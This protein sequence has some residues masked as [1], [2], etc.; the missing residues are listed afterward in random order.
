MTKTITP[1]Q[2][3]K[4][5]YYIDIDRGLCKYVGEKLYQNKL[6]YTFEYASNKKMFLEEN[7]LGLIRNYDNVGNDKAKKLN[8]LGDTSSWVKTKKKELEKVNKQSDELLQLYLERGKT[9]GYKYAKDT[10]EQIEF[11]KL[12]PYECTID[13]LNAVQDI[14]TDLENSIVVNR[15]VVGDVGYGKSEIYA[16]ASFKVVNN[17]KQVAVLLPSS[18]LANQS[19]IDLVD[20]FSSFPDIKI[21]LFSRDNT[22]KQTRENLEQTKNGEASIIVGTTAI[23]SDKVVFKD[24]GLLI[25]DECHKM[26]QLDKTK[27][28]KYQKNLNT[29]FFSATPQPAEQFRICSGICDLSK[30]LIAPCNKKAIITEDAEDS[31]RIIKTYIERELENDGQVYCLHN[32]C[33][34]IPLTKLRLEEL[35]PDIKIGVVTG[36]MDQAE[37]KETMKEFKD[38]KYDLLLATTVIECGINNNNA[39]TIIILE[40]ENLGLASLHQVRGRVGRSTLQ[41]YALLLYPRGIHLEQKAI[42]RLRTMKENSFLGSGF[43]I[44]EKD[45]AMRGSGELLG[46]SQSGF[47]SSIGMDY[48]NELLEKSIKDKKQI[49]DNNKLDKA[50]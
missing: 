18:V 46:K 1:E 24:L 31:D 30:L 34:K 36:Q 9:E 13:Q 39:N 49:I 41:G 5:N 22:A 29:L 2:L 47:M 21:V 50:I 14:K 48:F 26:G 19:Y 43:T 8:K 3:I 10:N 32:D 6:Y 45:R 35:I 44:S 11:E 33:Q 17:G 23:C 20:R 15:L 4:D 42:E 40:S 28:Q 25:V 27:L 7:K 37:A 38:G 12:F 16:R